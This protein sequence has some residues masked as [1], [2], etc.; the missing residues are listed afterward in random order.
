MLSQRAVD[1]SADI[2]AQ[3]LLVLGR[4]ALALRRSVGDDGAGDAGRCGE[5]ESAQNDWCDDAGKRH[6]VAVDGGG[7]GDGGG[8]RGGCV[9]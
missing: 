4:D 7:D 6:L 3:A 2:N 1:R 5:R 9:E 8:E